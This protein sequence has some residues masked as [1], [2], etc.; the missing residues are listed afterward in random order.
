MTTGNDLFRPAGMDMVASPP[1]TTHRTYM[2]TL[3]QG[4]WGM[5]SWAMS[6]AMWV[7][8]HP[9]VLVSRQKDC[10]VCG[11]GLLK[12]GA[13]SGLVEGNLLQRKAARERTG[14]VGPWRPSPCPAHHPPLEFWDWV[15]LLPSGAHTTALLPS[16]SFPP[17]P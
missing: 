14:G 3:P 9:S 16:L 12:W 10:L 17:Q 11:T 5:L 8:G 2:L 13:A 7:S 4:G 15:S 1:G 6:P